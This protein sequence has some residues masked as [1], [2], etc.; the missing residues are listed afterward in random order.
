VKEKEVILDQHEYQGKRVN[1]RE[2]TKKQQEQQ[3]TPE[4]S[5]EHQKRGK[6]FKTLYRAGELWIFKMMKEMDPGDLDEQQIKVRPLWKRYNK[7]LRILGVF[8]FC[9]LLVVAVPFLVNKY[10]FNLDDPA[11]QKDGEDGTCRIASGFRVD[12]L[13]EFDNMTQDMDEAVL[14]ICESRGCCWDSSMSPSCYHSLPA[15]SSS[16]KVLSIEST[17]GGVVSGTLTSPDLLNPTSGAAPNP[18]NLPFSASTDSQ[19][20][21]ALVVLGEESPPLEGEPCTENCPIQVA[22]GCPGTE[23]PASKD[24]AASCLDKMLTVRLKTQHGLPAQEDWARSHFGP[25]VI[26]EALSQISLYLPSSRILAPG[27]SEFAWSGIRESWQ[28]G[29]GPSSSLHLPLVLVF[30]PNSQ[31]MMLWLETDRPGEQVISPGAGGQ[32]LLTWTVMGGPLKIHL[33]TQ[34]TLD[35]LL[36]QMQ[37][38]FYKDSGPQLPP[39]WTLGYH[40]CRSVGGPDG[41]IYRENQIIAPMLNEWMPFDSDCID[42]RL[43]DY[44]F[45]PALNSQ[46]EPLFLLDLIVDELTSL[47]KGFVLPMMIQTNKEPCE[48]M[49][50][51]VFS[52]SNNS[53]VLGQLD[54]VDVAFPDPVDPNV[55]EWIASGYNATTANLNEM[56]KGLLLRDI[57]PTDQSDD[58]AECEQVQYK[59][60]G[61]ELGETVCPLHWLPST[62]GSLLSAHAKYSRAT[63][64]AFSSIPD[65]E[66]PY[67]F[68]DVYSIGQTGG[69][70]GSEA[71]ATWEAM[72][73]ALREVLILGL[74]GQSVVAMPACGTHMPLL[75]E[76][77]LTASREDLSLLCLRW[78]QLAAL[79]PSLRSHFTGKVDVTEDP[80]DM[81][82]TRMPNTLLT[83]HKEYV[84]WAIQRRY[85]LAPY[86]LTLQTDWAKSGVPL[87]KPMLAEFLSPQFFSTWRQFM[88]GPD[89]MVAPVL[90]E[91]PEISVQIPTGT[92]FDLYSKIRVESSSDNHILDIRTHLYSIPVFQRG[93]SVVTLF[94]NTTNTTSLDDTVSKSGL[95]LSVA[96]ACPPSP[97]FS[98]RSILP[99]QASTSIPN[100]LTM[101][102]GSEDPRAAVKASSKAGTGS[103]NITVTGSVVSDN[104]LKLDFIDIV[105]LDGIEEDMKVVVPGL[106]DGGALPKCE[107]TDGGSGGVREKCYSV[108]TDKELLQLVSLGVDIQNLEINFNP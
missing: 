108:D 86:L 56:P 37:T 18:P 64:S 9:G 26:G 32:A 35:E 51:A 90:E 29:F 65:S 47:G 75:E 104:P 17:A 50:C 38:L 36:K 42:E 73:G 27:L 30:H 61:L 66:V 102:Q 14:K 57:R 43:F 5:S 103:V 31:W 105:G 96:L 44:A 77:E 41:P 79:M 87:V 13:P 22:L 11:L 58:A 92:W 81:W 78:F 89:L 2:T 69:Y 6:Y 91:D 107:Q 10:E 20:L 63:A 39:S 101:D 106:P 99:C 85:Q 97:R 53:L 80:N 40:L 95:K 76:G 74:S 94:S 71:P 70:L 8:F 45:H 16:A 12:C 33:L 24:L 23:Y 55:A 93:G 19:G 100:L 4:N 48:T 25:I 34:P 83:S 46:L 67:L 88:L 82:R 49:A 1:S 52:K 72:A 54:N 84:A 15:Y 59:P 7:E 28:F 62:N 21:H 60:R 3:E 98:S 68:S